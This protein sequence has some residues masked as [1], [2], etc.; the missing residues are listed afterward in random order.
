MSRGGNIPGQRPKPRNNVYTVMAFTAF[1]AL[2]TAS[3]IVWYK[4]AA[5]TFESQEKANPQRNM[6]NP[7][8]LID[9]TPTK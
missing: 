3:G 7:M 2:S 9:R 4:N 1:A 5:L 6:S 8:F